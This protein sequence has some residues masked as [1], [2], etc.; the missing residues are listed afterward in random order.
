MRCRVHR[1]GF[2]GVKFVIA[3]HDVYRGAGEHSGLLV[4]RKFGGWWLK[5]RRE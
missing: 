4:T 1:N 2:A 3:F 5:Q